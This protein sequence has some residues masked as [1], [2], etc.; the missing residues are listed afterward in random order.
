MFIRSEVTH[1]P[2]QR[3]TGIQTLNHRATAYI[4]VYI[5]PSRKKQNF[6]YQPHITG[7]AAYPRTSFPSDQHV[8]HQEDKQISS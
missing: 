1:A 2:V 3:G 4:T 8:Q 7:E 6:S 5:S